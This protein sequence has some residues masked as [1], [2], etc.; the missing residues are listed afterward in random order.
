MASGDTLV[1]FTA[2]HNEPPSASAATLDTRNSHPI[3]DFDAGST[4]ESAVFAAVLP[5]HYGGGGVT[6]YGHVAMSTATSGCVDIEASFERIGWASQD[7]DSDGFAAVNTADDIA[8]DGTSGNVFSAS[9]AFTDGVDM[10]SVA[11][12]EGFRLKFS[13]NGVTDGAAGD[14]E[15]RFIEIKET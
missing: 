13:R 11:A 7:I 10:D 4:L 6:V 1:V 2:L 3:L 12:G 8:V 5:R 14:M 15:L 9:V